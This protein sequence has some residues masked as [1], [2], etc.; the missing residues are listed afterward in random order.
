M[1]R[2]IL[3]KDLVLEDRVAHKT[4]KVATTDDRQTDATLWHKRDEC[5]LLANS[6]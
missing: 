6:A 4:A 2:P 3:K 5:H 1:K